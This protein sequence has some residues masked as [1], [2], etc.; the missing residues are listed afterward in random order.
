MRKTTLFTTALVAVGTLFASAGLAG[1]AAISDVNQVSNFPEA[2]WG[3]LGWTTVA[4]HPNGNSLVV[5]FGYEVEANSGSDGVGHHYA[6]LLGPDGAP[7]TDPV[8]LGDD[9]TDYYYSGPAVV[10]NPVTDGWS[11]FLIP[12][13]SG[14]ILHQ[15]INT[16]GSLSGASTEIWDSSTYPLLADGRTIAYMAQA[17]AVWVESENHFLFS[18]VVE[19]ITPLTNTNDDEQWMTF[20]VSS[21]GARLTGPTVVGDV[22]DPYANGQMA[23]SPTSDRALLV[24][25]G[26]VESGDTYAPFGQLVDGSGARVGSTIRIIP[27]AEASQVSGAGVSWNSSTNKFLVVWSSSRNNNC[28]TPTTACG[29]WGQLV[30]ADGTLS[31]DRITLFSTTDTTE[32]FYRPQLTANGASNEYVLVWHMGPNW[33]PGTNVWAL[34]VDGTGAPIGDELNVS[35]SEGGA[36]SVH[37]RPAVTLNNNACAYVVTWQGNPDDQAD[38]EL[39]HIYSRTIETGEVCVLPSTGLQTTTLMVGLAML[40]SGAAVLGGTRRRRL[41]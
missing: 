12:L 23:Y 39:Q 32:D 22:Y 26:Y 36:N 19:Y 37:Q 33:N 14:K 24:T 40:L 41:A 1:A 6:Q 30:N 3:D 4:A 13:D 20:T 5:Y 28:S 34:R 2:D 8:S 38:P 31:G 9:S 29:M 15:A 35:E 25:V 7:L 21:A 16:D 10:Y 17:N 11:A 18:A 27:N